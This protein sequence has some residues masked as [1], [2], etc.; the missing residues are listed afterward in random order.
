MASSIERFLI[1]RSP[2]ITIDEPI[3]KRG[4]LRSRRKR[5]DDDKNVSKKMKKQ[6]SV[7]FLPTVKIE[8]QLLWTTKYKPNHVGEMIGSREKF[9]EI[10]RYIEDWTS[11]DENEAILIIG[12][13]GVGKTCL[14]YAIAKELQ[15][16]IF[17][18]NCG[19][20][21][22]INYTTEKLHETIQTHQVCLNDTPKLTSLWASPDLNDR[23]DTA[24]I[25]LSSNSI[26]LFDDIDFMISNIVN[27]FWRVL[28]NLVQESKK[29]IILTANR[30]SEHL[31]NFIS[32]L[33]IFE[34]DPPKS[35]EIVKHLTEIVNKESSENR[36]LQLSPINV[37]T[38]NG[39]VR[40]TLNE[41]QYN[42][43][44]S[45]GDLIDEP[46]EVTLDDETPSQIRRYN[47]LCLNDLITTKVGILSADE[48]RSYFLQGR[49]IPF[50]QS[51]N[52]RQIADEFI[53][54]IEKLTNK[55]FG[56]EMIKRPKETYDSKK[57]T[58][59]LN[60]S[61]KKHGRFMSRQTIATEFFPY[62]SLITTHQNSRR[63]NTRGS[64]TAKV[65]IGPV[66][67]FLIKFSVI[68]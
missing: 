47:L 14:V 39:D 50:D 16:K 42:C 8:S 18:V 45:N 5:A 65:P 17:E 61:I 11:G 66:D 15:Y 57:F 4:K 41:H 54:T 12:P 19:L 38:F 49:D 24:E 43:N 51:I 34:M 52:C 29:P 13:P 36:P 9:I 67:P 2:V 63:Y 55:V 30:Y 3:G 6:P 59:K 64:R 1:R 26:I 40:R 60:D 7:E 48:T 25:S 53:D 58:N 20:T 22:K 33:K 35:E 46:M 31:E 21:E 32:P 10:K 27:G 56:D 37:T 62:M 44:N 28:K 23:D 68:D